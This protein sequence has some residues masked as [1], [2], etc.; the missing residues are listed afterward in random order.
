LLPCYSIDA[1]VD[2]T[3][4]GLQES[5]PDPL[6]MVRSS[7]KVIPALLISKWKRIVDPNDFE[8]ISPSSTPRTDRNP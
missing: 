2:Y 3:I 6:F 1:N 8:R 5:D 7:P 4:P